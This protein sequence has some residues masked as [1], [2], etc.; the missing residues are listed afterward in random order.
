ME[1]STRRQFDDYIRA[2]ISNICIGHGDE[3]ICYLGLDGFVYKIL[4]NDIYGNSVMLN[5]DV[6]DFVTVSDINVN[7]YLLPIELYSINNKV[8]GYTTKYVNQDLFFNNMLRNG[9]IYTI[10]NVDISY[11][12]DALIDFVLDNLFSINK[13]DI[14]L[15]YDKLYRDTVKLSDYGVKICNVNNNILFDG[16]SFFVV[17]TGSYFKIN[18]NCFLWNNHLIES[19]FKNELDVLYNLVCGNDSNMDRKIYSYVNC[20][21]NDIDINYRSRI[22]KR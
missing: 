3:G 10:D 12:K 21:W 4:Y 6:N 9:Y 18:D 20:M 19:A 1:F 16:N 15:A 22:K 11:S 17:D 14:K 13:S 8:V 5:Y 2:K 7:S